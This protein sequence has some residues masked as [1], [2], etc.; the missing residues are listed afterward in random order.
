MRVFLIIFFFI[1]YFIFFF[2]WGGGGGGGGGVQSRFCNVLVWKPG[3]PYHVW[4]S[5]LHEI[6]YLSH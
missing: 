2:F 6:R 3:L 5:I 1:F 4:T